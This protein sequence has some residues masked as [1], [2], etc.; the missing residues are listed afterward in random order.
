MAVQL[1]PV[2]IYALHG[3]VEEREGKEVALAGFVL[4]V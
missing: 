3:A 2:A 4:L 1:L